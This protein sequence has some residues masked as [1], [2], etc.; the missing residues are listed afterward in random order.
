MTL[1]IRTL[2]KELF[3]E[4]LKALE[5]PVN[6]MQRREVQT[7]FSKVIYEKLENEELQKRGSLKILIDRLLL[8]EYERVCEREFYELYWRLMK[9]NGFGLFVNPE[10]F[11]VNVELK[12]GSEAYEYIFNE[13]KLQTRETLAN[14]IE[15]VQEMS[16][17][18]LQ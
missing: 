18:Q 2:F 13:L 4:H 6:D 9:T 5:S 15:N 12:S 3:A 17:T 7:T 14:F 16:R 8:E 10:G 11:T 1:T